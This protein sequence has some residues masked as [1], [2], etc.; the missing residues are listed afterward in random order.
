VIIYRAEMLEDN[1]EFWLGV[2]LGLLGTL[3]STISKIFLKIAHNIS[4]NPGQSWAYWAAGILLLAMNPP[5]SILALKHSPEAVFAATGGTAAMF[6]LLLAPWLLKETFRDWDVYGAVAICIGC[7]GLAMAQAGYSESI[8]ESYPHLMSRFY[9]PEF[10]YFCVATLAFIAVLCLMILGYYGDYYHKCAIGALSGTLGGMLF[11]LKSFLICFNASPDPWMHSTTYILG[12]L[13]ILS[14]VGGVMIMNEGLK[15][16]D[17]IFI[18]PVYQ[19]FLVLMGAL[20]GEAFFGEVRRL[21][22]GNRLV[23]AVSLAVMCWGIRCS[24]AP[25]QASPD[26]G[27]KAQTHVLS[28]I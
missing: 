1:E 3:M 8:V 13:S 5:L 7:A 10:I 12:G 25:W 23:S 28:K 18:A 21:P 14:A 26:S 4:S 19:A 11:I 22:P 27:T 9:Q 15:R 20:S 24:M 2:G 6:N 17:T 16:Y